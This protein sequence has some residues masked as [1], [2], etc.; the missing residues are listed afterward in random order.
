MA[1]DDRDFDA[2]GRQFA[3]DGEFHGVKGREQIVDFYRAR[4]S[5]FSTSSHYALTWHFDFTDDDH[6]SGVV[7]AH[8]ELC[9][10][11]KTV[12]LAL[13]Y[14]D[15]YVRS[16]QGWLF[17]QR[18]LKFRY[19]LPFDAVADS[20]DDPL[21]VRWPGTAPQLADLPDKLQ[22]FIDSRK[23][24][25]PDPRGYVTVGRRV[26][27]GGKFLCASQLYLPVTRFARLLRMAE[28]RLAD[29]NL[30]AVLAQEFFAP[31][32]QSEGLAMLVALSAEDAALMEIAAP[33]LGL[34]VHITGRSFGRVPV[35]FQRMV[36]PPTRYA[37]K[38]DFLPLAAAGARLP[39]QLSAALAT[40]PDNTLRNNAFHSTYLQDR[41]GHA[42]ITPITPAEAGGLELRQRRGQQWRG[43]GVAVR[44][45]G[46]FR[47]WDKTISIRVQ[48]GFLR[49]GDQTV[50]RIGDTRQGSPGIRV[51]TCT[52]SPRRPSAPIR[53][54]S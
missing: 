42:T 32:L 27:I 38:L 37:L 10:G 52:A 40:I 44:P 50:L 33:S 29:S 23:A 53:P 20:L 3:P 5:T 25:G 13:R 48:R 24:L 45:E 46:Q 18:V 4:T 47:P 43:A 1:V 39:S 14:L 34:Q 8:A 12:R 22:T 28:G 49:A 6:A 7:N 30:K 2:I 41:V 11:G 16:P 26:D 15:R 35:T 51:Q 31:T 21:R 17:Q 19:V 54:A 36:V 9:I